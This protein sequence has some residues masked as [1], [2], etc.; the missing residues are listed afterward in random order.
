MSPKQQAAVFTLQV[1]FST[2]AISAVIGLGMWFS[3]LW[4]VIILITVFLVS[5]ARAV[6]TVKLDRINYERERINTILSGKDAQQ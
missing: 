5:A 2:V 1:M 6:Y 4:T 3:E